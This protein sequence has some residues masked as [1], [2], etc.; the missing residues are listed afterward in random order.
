M[1]YTFS[2][3]TRALSGNESTVNGLRRIAFYV[4]FLTCF[5]LMSRQ[6]ILNLRWLKRDIPAPSAETALAVH[7]AK[8]GAPR[9]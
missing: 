8:R 6:N 4:S 3:Y 5:S 1:T 7:T 2:Q 9:R